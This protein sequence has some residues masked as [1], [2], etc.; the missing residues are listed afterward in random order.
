MY[1]VLLLLLDAGYLLRRTIQHTA[2]QLP[3]VVNHFNITSPQNKIHK[4]KKKGIDFAQ[5]QQQQNNQKNR[6]LYL[7][8]FVGMYY[9]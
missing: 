4:N 3:G 2:E 9:T 5:Q 8:K 7:L 1:T 6:I